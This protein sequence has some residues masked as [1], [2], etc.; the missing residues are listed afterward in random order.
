[1]NALPNT[2]SV[3]YDTTRFEVSN[4]NT[5]NKSTVLCLNANCSHTTLPIIYQRHY[6]WLFEDLT[7]NQTIRIIG[8]HLDSG[9]GSYN[10]NKRVDD[11]QYINTTAN[12][13]EHRRYPTFLVM[14]A[15]YGT[16]SGNFPACKKS[17]KDMKG[18]TNREATANGRQ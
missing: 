7:T 2:I 5:T 6:S 8:A 14:D 15:N 16:N 4:K 12:H 1:M 11:L 17:L 3:Y 18:D 9:D 10:Q 13:A